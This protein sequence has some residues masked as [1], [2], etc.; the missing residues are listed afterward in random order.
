MKRGP[1]IILVAA[2]GLVAAPA[3]NAASP[4]S[5][6]VVGGTPVAQGGFPYTAYI[7]AATSNGAATCT[8]S[9]IQPTIILTAAHCVFDQ[10]T[11]VALPASAFSVVT[12]TPFVP[13]I[14]PPPRNVS[15]VRSYP[16]YNS[17]TFQGDAA[18][19]VLATPTTA[20]SIALA[21]TAQSALY[22][23]G[24]PVSYAGWGETVAD[25]PSS[26]PTQLQSGAASILANSTCAG[27]VQFHPGLTLCV[28]APNYT[29]AVCHGDSG[30]PLVETTAA[31]PVEVGITSYGSK[32][33]CGVAPDYFTRVSSVQ[34]WITS[35]IAGT[36]APPPFVPPFNAPAAPAAALAGDGV[37]AAFAA[38]AADPATMLTN[39]VVILLAHGIA[40]STQTL[41]PTATTA[42]FPSL[43][44]GTYT[45]SVMATYSEGSSVPVPSAPVTLAP[46]RN[47]KRPAVAGPRVVGY[48]VACKYGTWAWPGAATFRVA[49][50]R[51]GK[52][53]GGKTGLTYRV[54]AA[55]VGKRLA[56]RVTLRASTGPTATAVSA[57]VRP[58]VR[59]RLLAAPRVRG[60]AGIG[61]ALV[62]TT[63]RWAHTGPLGLSVTWRRDGRAI[64]GATSTRHLV[65]AAD[66]GHALSC[67]VR[68]RAT[69]QSATY[70]TGSLQVP[71]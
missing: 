17:T 7:Q 20:P 27:A 22:T 8:G 44:P 52:A 65:A 12:G 28:A 53:L 1:L 51:N 37:S 50:L 39:L 68:I 58:G 26:T 43:Q 59:L 34:S 3:A 48:R 47:R 70:T 11:G 45:V 35:A 32:T 10:G 56:C 2:L 15:A 60:V 33:G 18:I 69:D 66:A 61:A 24:Q 23:A 38:P 62:C 49:W 64:A 40:V 9:V 4:P 42:V 46:P 54:Q 29:P 6:Y 55:D 16:Y 67:K 14:P 19:L 21:T 31:G 71:G 41:V 30:G 13:A 5:P 63:G 36:T 57:A 25:T